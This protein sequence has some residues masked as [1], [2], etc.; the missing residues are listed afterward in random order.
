MAPLSTWKLVIF[1]GPSMALNTM[2][3]PLL[4]LLPQ[5]YAVEVGLDIAA[6]GTVFM[7]ARLWDAFTDP[8]IGTLSDRTRTRWGRRRPWL[9]AGLP[10]CMASTWFLL[11]PPDGAGLGYLFLWVLLFYVFWTMMFIPYQAWGTELATG[12]HERTRVAGFRDGA[13]FLGYLLATALPLVVLQIVGGIEAPSYAQMLTVLGTFFLVSLPLVTALCVWGIPEPRQ[14]AVV[15]A[16]WSQLI[17][18][19]Q[20]GPFVRLLAAFTLDRLAMGIYFAVMP[21][22]VSVV[23]GLFDRFLTL[24]LTISI[25]SLLFS[26]FWVVVAGKVGKHRAYCLA[27]VVTC[28]AYAGFLLTPAGNFSV[29]LAIFALLGVGNAGTL[30]TTPSMMADCIDFDHWRSGVEQTGAHMAFLWLVTK[31]GFALGIGVSLIYLGWFG[32]SPVGPNTDAALMAARFGTGGLPILLIVP[33]IALMLNFPIGRA[34]HR[35]IR[36]RL[37]RRGV[38]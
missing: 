17:G 3:V 29:A 5:F 10:L 32:F 27:N 37:A 33:A 20:N 25:T 4:L 9:L 11:N 13:S 35:A 1:S 24:S 30:I 28:A 15:N 16:G 38:A 21:L 18:L 34:A 12:F 19:L 22:T 23:L 8:T 31:V 6:I 14:R 26:P 7:V 36:G 2:L